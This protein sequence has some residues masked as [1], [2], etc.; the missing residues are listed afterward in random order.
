MKT[1]KTAIHIA[2]IKQT[3]KEIFS[4]IA[5]RGIQ[6]TLEKGESVLIFA[7]KKGVHTGMVC[8]E[9]WHIP[10][11]N[12]C[13]IPIWLYQNLH[14]HMFWLC[15]IC[16]HTYEVITQCPSCGH[17]K[18]DPYW[19]G[20]QQVAEY[21]KK[22]FTPNVIIIQS[23]NSNSHPKIQ[24]LFF[25]LRQKPLIIIATSLLQYSVVKVWLL[26]FQNALQ[27]NIPDYNTEL[28][29]YQFLSTAIHSYQAPHAI[30]QTYQ[31][32]HAIIQSISQQDPAMFLD[33]DQVFRIKHHYPPF[34]EL[35][36]I[37][38]KHVIETSLFT[39]VNNLFHDMLA[40]KQKWGY[41]HIQVYAIP[42]MIYKIYGKYRYQIV[43]KWEHIRE[44]I[45]IVFQELKP[46]S[47]WFKFDRG[48]QS[49]F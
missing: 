16:Q 45:D 33:Q 15:P 12:Q 44:F 9:C 47:K 24:Q 39:S 37:S 23:S 10:Y 31:P 21:C 35:C 7:N 14:N 11:C 6:K 40:L 30:I 2:D 32:D 1:H 38:Y 19:V 22:Q 17:G 26:V 34:G 42:A 49:F 29:N 4:D 41:E 28:R 13:D 48:A 43:I 5:K 8:K 25:Q 36:I 18:L 46:Y 20:I 27:V 3:S